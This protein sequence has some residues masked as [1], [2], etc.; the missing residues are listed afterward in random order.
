[1]LYDA[2]ICHA[3][4][5]KESFV[6]LLAEALRREQ[7]EVWYDEFSLKIGDSIR[8]SLD[9]GLRQSRFGI[10]VLSPA[11]FKKRWP[12]YELDGL[13]E[14]EMRGS[15]KVILPVWH[16]VTHSDVFEFS[17]SL[18]NRHAISSSRGIDQVVRALFEVIHPQG[19]PLIAAR[20]KLLEWGVTPPV[21]TDEYWLSVVE[22]SNRV[23]GMGAAVPVDSAWERWSFPLPEKEGGPQKWGERLAWTA[24]QL[25]WV[26]IAEQ[27]N[28]S[29][30]T[31][32]VTVLK[33]IE[34]HT[35]LYETCATYPE[36]LAEYAPQLTIPGMGGP[37][38]EYFEKLYQ[39]SIKGY[40][41]LRA[42]KSS[43]GIATTTTGNCPL[44]DAIWALRSPTFGDYEPEHVTSEYFTGGMFGP[45]VSSY[46]NL[47]HLVWL[48]SPASEWL[49]AKVR[50]FLING[51]AKW[52]AWIGDTDRPDVENGFSGSGAFSRAL[53]AATDGKAFR[54]SRNIRDDAIRHFSLAIKAL[55]ISVSPEKILAQFQIHKFPEILISTKKNH[56][57][58]RRA[59]A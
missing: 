44:C 24:M 25:A 59:K 47:E 35:G 22:A 34:R 45:S 53:Y 38:E 6:K 51:M 9:K 18:A 11:F 56:R 27:Q 50:E 12:Q 23:P 14:R 21:I 13:A 30:L 31:D 42:E 5:D 17:P 36:L 26:R 41:R 54:W 15:D 2:F 49:P 58:R 28:I 8:R 10:V 48:L 37:F 19:S 20:E 57:K 3:S 55:D 43:C 39:D 33:F 16:G 29:P 4:E 40:T 46:N 7:V 1:M 52:Q 32:P